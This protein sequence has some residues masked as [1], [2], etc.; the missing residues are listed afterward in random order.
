MHL[1]LTAQNQ[2]ALSSPLFNTKRLPKIGGWA[3]I[4]G[5]LPDTPPDDKYDLLTMQ[6]L[7][8]GHRLF[9]TRAAHPVSIVGYRVNMTW[10][11]LSELI[12]SSLNHV[13]ANCIRRN[14]WTIHYARLAHI[15][16]HL[17]GGMPRPV[18]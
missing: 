7:A 4:C 8:R 16:M 5:E 12:A 2:E 11:D 18:Y 14:C 1:E 10:K 15:A 3:Y 6:F 9:T 17:K 13:D